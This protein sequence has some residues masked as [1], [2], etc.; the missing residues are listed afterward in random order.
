MGCSLSYI[1]AGERCNA[2]G[3]AHEPPY[4]TSSY[5]SQMITSDTRLVALKVLDFSQFPSNL[6]ALILASHI[7]PPFAKGVA[8]ATRVVQIQRA[9]ASHDRQDVGVVVF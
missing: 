7:A 4:D 5:T 2:V 3:A 6:H 1:R 9:A 8:R